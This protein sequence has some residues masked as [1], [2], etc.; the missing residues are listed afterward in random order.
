VRHALPQKPLS[1]R[2]QKLRHSI[3]VLVGHRRSAALIRRFFATRNAERTCRSLAACAYPHPKFCLPPTAHIPPRKFCEEFLKPQKPA[4][5]KACMRLA[6]GEGR[7]TQDVIRE[8]S[9]CMNQAG[10]S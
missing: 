1:W 7:R 4:G 8:L 2:P 3:V 6:L 5:W 9:F 10:V